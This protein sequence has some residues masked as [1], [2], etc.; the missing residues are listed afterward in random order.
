M[1][2]FESCGMRLVLNWLRGL[3]PRLPRHSSLCLVA[4]IGS[5]KCIRVT[6]VSEDHC[7]SH[8][9]HGGLREFERRHTVPNSQLCKQV[10][11]SSDWLLTLNSHVRIVRLLYIACG[12]SLS[13]FMPSPITYCIA[14]LYSKKT[15]YIK[16]KHLTEPSSGYL[17]PL[18]LFEIMCTFSM[19]N[20]SKATREVLV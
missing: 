15:M 4:H 7:V 6:S 3:A 18:T 13:V 8:P 11:G 20:R 19:S 9:L 12:L 2:S 10:S 17:I 16:N 1:M 14:L 5:W